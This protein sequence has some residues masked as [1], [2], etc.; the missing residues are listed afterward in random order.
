MPRNKDPPPANLN[1]NLLGSWL[2]FGSSGS[3]SNQAIRWQQ[4]HEKPW[5]RTNKAIPRFLVQR[6][7]MR[8]LNVSCFNPVSFEAILATLPLKIH[9]SLKKLFH[10]EIWRNTG[11]HKNKCL[12][13][14]L[15]RAFILQWFSKRDTACRISKHTSVCETVWR[16]LRIWETV[17]YYTYKS[18]LLKYLPKQVQTKSLSFLWLA[19]LYIL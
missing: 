3:R 4:P 5:A 7:C 2:T 9:H 8:R 17:L 19:V 1:T 16:I 6:S 15:L 13:C 10:K 18:V 12:S 14:G 11:W